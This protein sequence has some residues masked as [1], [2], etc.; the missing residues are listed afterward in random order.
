MLLICQKDKELFKPEDLEEAKQL[1]KGGAD[2]NAN[3]RPYHP[4]IPC[5]ALAVLKKNVE[6]VELLLMQPGINVNQRNENENA[7]LHFACRR[8]VPEAILKMLLDRPE[9]ELNPKCMTGET[10]IMDAFYYGNVKAIRRLAF[11]SRVELDMES[12]SGDTLDIIAE[13]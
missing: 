4:N 2:P 12:K 1:L 5:L 9:I 10:P 11:D 3:R 7:A 6:L 8:G 13:R